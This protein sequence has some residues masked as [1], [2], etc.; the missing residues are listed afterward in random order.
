VNRPPDP[1]GIRELFQE[2]QPPPGVAR[3]RVAAAAAARREPARAARPRRRALAVAAC[4]VAVAVVA[5][6]GPVVSRL[7]HH[8]PARPGGTGGIAPAPPVP[9]V[10]ASPTG[11]ASS[12]SPDAG[13]TS[14]GP[15]ATATARPGPTNTGVPAGMTLRTHAGDLTVT[16]PGAVVDALLVTG[17]ILVEAPNV[18]IRRTRVAPDGKVF[19]AIRQE[20]KATNLTV[21]DSEIAGGGNHID[22]SQEED[23]LAVRR[24]LFRD[25]DI[26]IAVGNRA[27]VEDSYFHAVGTGVGTTGG[28][29]TVTVHH[30]TILT[31]KPAESAIGMLTQRGPLTAVTIDDNLLGGGNYTVHFGEGPASQAVTVRRNRFSRAVYLNG[32]YY[33]PVAG[34]DARAPRNAWA[35]NV[36]DDTGAPVNP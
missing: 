29:A 25:A 15:P 10:S 8:A 17:S 31:S 4:A 11:A 9:P 7:L 19:W 24:C 13:P 5:G 35:D 30:N 12:V 3:W 1:D 2:V 36:W 28:V 33:G 32:G 16:T 23:G 26:G 27:T 6:A 21:E 18:T 20:P 34:W 14:L 22:L